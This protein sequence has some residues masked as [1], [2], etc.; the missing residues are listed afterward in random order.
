MAPL[1]PT[2]LVWLLTVL[3]QT[4]ALSAHSP[5]DL[6]AFPAYNVVLSERAVLN[7]TALELL[8]GTPTPDEPAKS[9][10]RHL[11]RTPSGQAFLCTVPVVE[12]ERKTMDAQAERDAL[13]QAAERDKGLTNGL[14]LL[15]PMRNGCLYLRQGWFTYSFCYGSEIRQFHEI[16]VAGAIGPSEDPESESYSLGLMPESTS[17]A[18][19]P[20]YG[21][22]SAA[23]LRQERIPARLGGEASQG[24]GWDEG[25]RYLSQTWSSGTV[26]DKTGLPRE[27]EVQFHCNT[28]S[29]DRIAW[30]R[31]TSIC[32]YVMLIHTPRLCGEPIFLEGRTANVA[33]AAAIECQPVVRQLPKEL[34]GEETALAQAEADMEDVNANAQPD[35]PVQEQVSSADA[36]IDPVQSGDLH[37]HEAENQEPYF[38]E[39]YEEQETMLTLV[40]DPETGEIESAVTDSGEDVF[41]DSALRRMLFGEDEQEAAGADA[42]PQRGN[43]P[44]PAEAE[45]GIADLRQLIHDSISDALRTYAAQGGPPVAPAGEAA[46]AAAPAQQPPRHA[47]PP[48]L[49]QPLDEV[50]QSLLAAVRSPH[51]QA[52]SQ[53]PPGSQQGEQ[54]QQQQVPRRGASTKLQPG[55]HKYLQQFERERKTV[56][57]LQKAVLG[58]DEHERLKQRFAQRY[59]PHEEEEQDSSVEGQ[60][61]HVRDE[62]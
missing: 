16:R 47:A 29:I 21:S 12:E 25:G 24:L 27:V 55:L 36:P 22:G 17:I 52:D 53:A 38:G 3:Q 48:L 34:S 8:A 42:A 61:E 14:A 51:D 57:V 5:R 35:S 58:S 60:E 20:K 11:L 28:Q 49:H 56:Q 39:S 62:L 18:K 19:T 2:R 6:E 43:A 33:P 46:A 31:E 59:E 32:R 1:S 15:E 4:L 13:V 26:C 45:A 37:E 54:Q 30:I 40:Y 7:E 23:V 44:A 10:R 9:P 41:L 50:V